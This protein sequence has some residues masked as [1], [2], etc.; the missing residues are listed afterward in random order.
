MRAFHES[1]DLE[2]F[3]PSDTALSWS[4]NSAQMHS[5]MGG[6]FAEASFPF[7]ISCN[8]VWYLKKFSLLIEPKI[9]RA[10]KKLVSQ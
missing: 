7:T 10:G 1:P 9:I 5:A 6:S 3:L 4:L 8:T 2:W